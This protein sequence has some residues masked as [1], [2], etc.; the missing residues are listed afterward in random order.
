MLTNTEQYTDRQ[1]VEIEEFRD[2]IGP[3]GETYI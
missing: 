2:Q 1:Q 3:K